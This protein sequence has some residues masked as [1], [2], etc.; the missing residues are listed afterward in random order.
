MYL[1]GADHPNKGEARR[2]LDRAIDDEERFVTDAEVFQEILHRYAAIRRRQA[3][4][5]AFDSL[6]G[7]VS[8]VLPIEM[9]DVQRARR[10]LGSGHL[11]ARDALH[12]AVMQRH[13]ISRI[14]TFD[15]GFDAVAGIERIQ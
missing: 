4:A 5:P 11:S 14:L 1:V 7:V 15:R 10:L 13:D 12:A 9:S 2:L 6:V 3:I 8:E